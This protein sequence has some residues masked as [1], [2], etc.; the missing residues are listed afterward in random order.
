MPKGWSDHMRGTVSAPD[1][2]SV[3]LATTVRDFR[4]AKLAKEMTEMGQPQ[5]STVEAI[6]TP[7]LKAVGEDLVGRMRET[8]RAPT[9][10]D[11]DAALARALDR[12]SATKAL[13]VMDPGSRGPQPN[14]TADLTAMARA[15]VDIHQGT[16]DSALRL[17]D[18]ERERRLEAEDSVGAAA[19]HAREEERTKALSQIDFV[20]ESASEIRS[21]MKD[22]YEERLVNKETTHQAAIERMEQLA[23]DAVSRVTG[24]YEQR[25]HEQ[26]QRFELEKLSINKDHEIEKLRMQTPHG[27]TP[28]DVVNDAWAEATADDLKESAAIKRDK[29][30]QE[31]ANS[32]RTGDLLEQG[33]NMVPQLLGALVGAGQPTPRNG[34][35]G[36]P[37]PIPE[38]E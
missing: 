4:N 37:P 34:I 29:L 6:I 28:Q 36:N 24:A 5:H 26:E 20:R 2:A 21:L 19:A 11:V 13:E 33:I 18:A 38:A 16:A 32:E 14:S 10:T 15:A 27:K 1:P 35:P 30:R 31:L 12:A 25:L 9:G 3:E 7:I 23:K 17:A 8:G 22:V